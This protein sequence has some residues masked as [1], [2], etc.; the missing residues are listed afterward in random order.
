MMFLLGRH[1]M[2][3]HD[4]PMYLRSMTATR[5][6][7]PANVQAAI[8]EPV[9]PPSITRSN[10]SGSTFSSVWVNE[11]FSVLFMKIFLSERQVISLIA[12]ISQ[13]RPADAPERSRSSSS[14]PL[15][16]RAPDAILSQECFHPGS[17]FHD[18][19]LEGKMA[20]IKELNP[21]VRQVFS[22]CLCSWRY[23]KGIILAPDRK[24]WRLRLS[25]I[26]LELRIK[27]HVRRIVQK[28]IELNLFVSRPFQQSPIQ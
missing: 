28:Q 15:R 8:V 10:S 23:E 17:N 25:K 4:P 6:P 18:V 1:A 22:K 9:P 26:F 3:G 2:F 12:W 11:V 21:C 19:C 5:C 13:R 7:S 20:G 27:P 16:L 14:R 24:Q